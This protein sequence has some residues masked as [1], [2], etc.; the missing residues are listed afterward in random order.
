MKLK[1]IQLQQACLHEA[2]DVTFGDG[3]IGIFGPQGSG[4]STLLNLAY[5]AITNDYSRI[6]GGKEGAVRQQSDRKEKS[7]IDLW[8]EHGG[9]QFH[10]MR[11]LAPTPAH[12]LT[13][14]DQPTVKKANEIQQILEGVLGIDRQTLDRYV[15]VE[16]WG[17]RALFQQTPTERAKT[18]AHLCN[19]TH[20]ETCWDLVGKQLDGDLRLAGEVADNTDELR[21]KAGGHRAELAKIQ[22]SQTELAPMLLT[23]DEVR[24]IKLRQQQQHRLAWLID[25]LPKAKQT[26][27]QLLSSA[28]AAKKVADL[29]AAALSDCL[30]A[31]AQTAEEARAT[32]QELQNYNAAFKEWRRQCDEQAELADLTRRLQAVSPIDLSGETAEEIEAAMEGL[33]Q[34]IAPHQSLLNQSKLAK[35]ATTCPTCGQSIADVQQRLREANDFVK[36]LLDEVA[37]LSQRLSK[38]R[39]AERKQAAWET[40]RHNLQ[41]AH[42][43]LSAKLLAREEAADPGSSTSVELRN[44]TATKKSRDAQRQV[45]EA[46]RDLA[47]AS[48]VKTATITRHMTAKATLQKLQE[49]HDQLATICGEASDV[50]DDVR[51]ATHQ[52]ARERLAGLASAAELQQQ[53]LDDCEKEITRIVALLERSR[54]AREWVDSLQLVRNAF[55]RDALPRLVHHDALAEMED[56]INAMLETFESPF[57]VKTSDDLSYVAHFRNGTVMPAKGLSGG[58]QV[59]LAIAF[60]WVLN[61]LFAGQIGMMILDE[62]TAG[63]DRRHVDL[64]ETALRALG[65]EARSR[66]CQVMLVTHELSLEPVFDQVVR[67]GKSVA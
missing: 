2:Q 26:E 62:P 58:Q 63:L 41:E 4:K 54:R 33:R 53:M 46:H 21:T 59:V 12:A 52:E 6:E 18:L 50:G 23:E 57:R 38:R 3:L 39:E 67:L 17:L 15:F 66:G 42:A 65:A 24:Q 11:R 40:T 10:L 55:H 1:R 43:K 29:A 25:E 20:A 48:D 14:N 36:P 51:L 27:E 9:S 61:S 22:Q 31:A 34:Q 49:E 19:T 7:Q 47:A 37:E 60:R 35:N 64:L 32:A 16:Q 28:R 30:A 13:I 8:A 5:A 44:A 45:D 56:G